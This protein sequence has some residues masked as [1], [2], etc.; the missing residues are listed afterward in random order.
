MRFHLF[1]SLH[2][3]AN[4]STVKRTLLCQQF[5]SERA[6]TYR[7]VNYYQESTIFRFSQGFF[8]VS[9]VMGW[10]VLRFYTNLFLFRGIS[11][12]N[13]N[14]I[15][16]N[17]S[18]GMSRLSIDKRGPMYGCRSQPVTRT[19][20]FFPF[21]GFFSAVFRGDLRSGKLTRFH[22]ICF[23]MKFPRFK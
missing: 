13:W 12:K 20:Q 6:W 19:T 5:W 16:N 10:L 2:Y 15:A 8:Q 11:L 7:L 21:K 17:N 23:K 9:M 4:K 22:I 14:N 1:C 3:R 18:F